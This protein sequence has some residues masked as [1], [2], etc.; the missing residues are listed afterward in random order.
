MNKN[1]IFLLLIILLSTIRVF[2]QKKNI[3]YIF[4]HSLINHALPI[5]PIPSQETSV[6]HW[7]HFLADHTGHSYEVSGQFGFLPQHADLPPT[8]QWG[9]DNVTGAWDSDNEPFSE[10]GFDNIMVTPGNFM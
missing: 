1:S 5:N 6:P 7:I 2:S 4:G 8:A 3:S 10:V 9:F